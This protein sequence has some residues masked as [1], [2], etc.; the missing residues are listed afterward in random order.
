MWATWFPAALW[1]AGAA[2]TSWQSRVGRLRPFLLPTVVLLV[3]WLA[4]CL[5]V[6]FDGPDSVGWYVVP[7]FALGMVAAVLLGAVVR[8]AGPARRA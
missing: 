7:Q 2:V 3:A 1:L 4:T 6:A 5:L 8:T